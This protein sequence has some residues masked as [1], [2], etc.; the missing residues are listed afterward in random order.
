MVEAKSGTNPVVFG[1]MKSGFRVFCASTEIGIDRDFGI[2]RDFGAKFYCRRFVITDLQN[3]REL[4]P[5][6]KIAPFCFAK[7]KNRDFGISGSSGSELEGAGEPISR[8]LEG[9][10]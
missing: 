2:H 5:R 7:Q 10:V 9:S 6:R 4:V 8:L 3:S 1:A